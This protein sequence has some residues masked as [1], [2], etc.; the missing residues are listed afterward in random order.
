MTDDTTTANAC[1]E[2]CLS[3]DLTRSVAAG[4]FIAAARAA[5]VLQLLGEYD[6]A[7]DD[8]YE[9]ARVAMVSAGHTAEYID[10]LDD[11][12]FAQAQIAVRS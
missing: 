12:A 7:T 3:P 9:T 5:A 4:N 6:E 10:R 2:A 8:A 11:I 1:R